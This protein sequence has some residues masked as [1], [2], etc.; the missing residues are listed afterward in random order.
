MGTDRQI[1][2]KDQAGRLGPPWKVAQVVY[3]TRLLAEGR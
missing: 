2:E 3:C 1:V